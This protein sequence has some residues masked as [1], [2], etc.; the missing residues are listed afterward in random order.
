MQ[1]TRIMGGEG[2]DLLSHRTQKQSEGSE[3]E[4]EGGA[5]KSLSSVTTKTQAFLVYT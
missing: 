1:E 5:K 2:G 4:S 3:R